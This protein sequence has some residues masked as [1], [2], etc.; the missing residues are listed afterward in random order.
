MYVHCDN[1][2]GGGATSRRTL[3]ISQSQG[4]VDLDL[5]SDFL[6]FVLRSMSKVVGSGAKRRNL[7]SCSRAG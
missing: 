4:E 7:S 6:D 5:R 2:R 3:A 1:D